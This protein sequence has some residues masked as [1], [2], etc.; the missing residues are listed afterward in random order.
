METDWKL[1]RSRIDMI[2][3]DTADDA[4]NIAD[5]LYNTMVHTDSNIIPEGCGQTLGDADHPWESLFTS[6]INTGSNP[7]S[8]ENDLD[9]VGNADI[10]NYLNV[11][12]NALFL[13]NMIIDH[14]L[15]VNDGNINMENGNFTLLNGNINMHNG[16]LTVNS[17]IIV[18]NGGVNILHGGMNIV[19]SVNMHNTLTVN[20]GIS[21]T[22]G[23]FNISLCPINAHAGLNIQNGTTTDTLNI[24]GQTTGGLYPIQII[25]GT[26]TDPYVISTTITSFSDNLFLINNNTGST[27][28]N[29][30]LPSLTTQYGAHLT[31]GTLVQ[32]GS[33]AQYYK[34][35]TP[36]SSAPIFGT[37]A[38]VT[39][40]GVNV[41]SESGF[42]V[43]NANRG[44]T[45]ELIFTPRGWL[46]K[47]LVAN[48]AKV[49]ML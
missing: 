2:T 1:F 20:N 47:G 19:D 29:I 15:T 38:G 24:T 27:T 21:L 43:I 46:L 31:I 7:L 5:T 40:G 16:I 36:S 26:T 45:H 35:E 34:I 3:L 37:I 48:G 14:N 4:I 18:N 32:L 10:G 44:E 6:I 8:I 39:G 41:Y 42:Q 11:V 17:G 12:G 28:Y 49:S 13:S 25:N 30:V 23:T 22:N 33:D 9:V